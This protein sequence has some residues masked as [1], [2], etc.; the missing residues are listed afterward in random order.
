MG[1]VFRVTGNQKHYTDLPDGEYM[2]FITEPVNIKLRRKYFALMRTIHPN[3][4]IADFDEFR[5]WFQM[6]AGF[7][8][9]RNIDG[10]DWK[11]PNKLGIDSMDNIKFKQFFEQCLQTAYELYGMD[12]GIIRELDK[13]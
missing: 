3:Q 10:L 7:Y 12:K 4:E 8:T 5:T 6:K 13:F 2:A 9:I 11:L 1:D